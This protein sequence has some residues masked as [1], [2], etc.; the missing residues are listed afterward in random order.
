MSEVD[1]EW[2][3]MLGDRLVDKIARRLIAQNVDT[4]IISEALGVSLESIIVLE[5]LE[6]CNRVVTAV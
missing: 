6:G 1:K 5:V 3:R 4:K 2:V